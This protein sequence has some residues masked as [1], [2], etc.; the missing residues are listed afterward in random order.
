MIKTFTGG[1]DNHIRSF[2]MSQ[3]GHNY[4]LPSN[5]TVSVTT[6]FYLSLNKNRPFSLLLFCERVT[7]IEEK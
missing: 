7:G 3:Y 4:L 5:L 1:A 2:F 6:I